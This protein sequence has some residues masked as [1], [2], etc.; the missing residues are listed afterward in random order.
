MP[1]KKSDVAVATEVAREAIEALQDLDEQW[2]RLA[3]NTICEGLKLGERRPGSGNKGTGGGGGSCGGGGGGGNG[4]SNTTLGT[5][6]EFMRQKR[7]QGPIQIVACL[8][9]YLSVARG[10]P[11]FKSTDLSALYEDTAYSERIRAWPVAVANAQKAKYL[12]PGK[13]HGVKQ[14]SLHGE[15]V[16]DALPSQ[17]AV[18]ALKAS[19]N[20][21]GRRRRR[22]RKAA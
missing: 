7:P 12:T 6:R 19:N 22:G 15:E 17:E 14:L 2:K 1:A 11:R 20:S 16:V 10:Q 9:K 8:G 4:V 5:P 3:I 21:G 18:R 13:G